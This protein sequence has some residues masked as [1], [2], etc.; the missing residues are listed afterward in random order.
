LKRALAWYGLYQVENW[1]WIEEPM[2][3]NQSHPGHKDA[4]LAGLTHDIACC[5]DVM[6]EAVPSEYE[7]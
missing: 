4:M 2:V 3:S 6:L 5:K 1:P 7:D